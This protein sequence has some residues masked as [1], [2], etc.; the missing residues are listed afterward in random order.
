MQLVQG[1]CS[2][3]GATWAGADR[4]HCS[5]CHHSWDDVELFDTHRRPGGV[6]RTPAELGLL[7][8]RNGIALRVLGQ[9]S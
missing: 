2:V 7:V 4:C 9:A 6:C 8:T 3:C 1:S 5:V